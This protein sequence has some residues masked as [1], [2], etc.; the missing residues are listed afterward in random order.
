MPMLEYRLQSKKMSTINNVAF[1]LP[2][3]KSIELLPQ[4]PLIDADTTCE[5]HACKNAIEWRRV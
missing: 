5:W 2:Y 1:N 4:A 3:P